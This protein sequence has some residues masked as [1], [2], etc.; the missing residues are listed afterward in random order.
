MFSDVKRDEVYLS[1]L[2]EC[3]ARHYGLE[4]ESI[5]PAKRGYYGE[6]WKLRA[7]G[8]AY[9]LKLSYAYLHKD[10]YENSLH[11]VDYLC[12][13]GIDFIGEIIKT[14]NGALSVRFD[15]AVLGIF[16]WIDGD[17]VQNEQTKIAEY[18]MLAKVYTVPCDGLS[19]GTKSDF[20]ENP[21][22]GIVSAETALAGATS[23]E[24]D[25]TETD[26][27]K[28]LLAGI[29]SAKSTFIDHISAK[30]VSAEILPTEDFSAACADL[31]FTQCETLRGMQDNTAADL[32]RLFAAHEAEIAHY[33]ERLRYFSR[34]CRADF[35][36]FHITHGDAG[37]NILQNGDRFSLVD[38]DS[39]LFA[40]PERD[41][42]FCMHWDWAM[43]AFHDALRQNG[44]SY[45]LQPE[46][47]AYYCYHFFFFYLTVYLETFFE[48]PQCREEIV[49][50]CAEY[51]PGWITDS[52]RFADTIV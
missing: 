36:H 23:A 13:H 7:N 5:T 29:A 25:L 14:T 43:R 41:A 50:D 33:A 40:P 34:K 48:L 22:T 24:F 6:T 16:A 35:S 15:S 32:L 26:L 37:G 39:P 8:K 4:A 46:R 42:W 3:I 19:L 51:F 52:L 38:W 2:A 10:T 18:Q 49:R 17:N 1:R 11:I 31:F 28:A 20:T 47:L 30:P 9:F 27:T 21:P 12:A 45:K 44:I